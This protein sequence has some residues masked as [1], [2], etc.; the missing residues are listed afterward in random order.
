MNLKCLGFLSK[1]KIIID[2]LALGEITPPILYLGGKPMADQT[3]Q[4]GSHNFT[5]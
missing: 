3:G 2:L 4:W 5:S 1:T